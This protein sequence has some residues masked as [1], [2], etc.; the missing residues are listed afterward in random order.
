M[1]SKLKALRSKINQAHGGSVF[2][3]ASS[4]EDMHRLSTGSLSFDRALGGGIPSGR[5][6]VVHGSESSGKTTLAC[7]TIARAQHL[8]ANCYRHVSDLVFTEEELPDGE[9]VIKT[10]GHCD[11]YQMGLFKT[12]R[13]PDENK[14][15]YK[16]RLKKY[17]EDSYREFQCA[18]IDPE[19]AYDKAWGEK[20][21]VDNRRLVYL[22]PDIA[23]HAI[24]QYDELLRTAEVDLIVL[25]SIAAMTPRIEIEKSAI[26]EQQALQ[27][28][29]IGK[30]TRRIVSAMTAVSTE[31]RRLPTHL[32]I[33]QERVSLAITWG[34][35]TVTPGGKA[36][37]FCA[38]AEIK[39]WPSKWKKEDRDGELIKDFHTEIGKQVRINIKVQK[40]KSAPAQQTGSCDL[41]VSG[42]G[43]GKFD[44]LKYFLAMAEKFGLIVER[45]DGKKKTWVVGDEVYDTKKAAIAR[46]EE[47]QVYAEMRKILLGKM[48]EGI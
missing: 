1:H 9:V 31:Y 15:E 18:L 41:V 27:A 17:E 4:I 37:K 38:T 25:D 43:A 7:S 16:A 29:V 5:V 10:I 33:N 45:E 40:N 36:P 42:E 13:F 22:R 14:D 24:D 47:P 19:G 28:R 23:E 44:E 39:M 11:C 35:N 30:F 20:I 48:L 32:W 2:R 12:M 21:G 8:C 3:I 6:T 34:D 46:V 26:E